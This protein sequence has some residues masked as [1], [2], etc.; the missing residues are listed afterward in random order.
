MTDMEQQFGGDTNFYGCMVDAFVDHVFSNFYHKISGD[1][2]RMWAPKID[3][4]RERIWRS[5]CFEKDPNDGQYSLKRPGYTFDLN[6]WRI[7]GFIDCTDVRTCRP[8]SGPVGPD[9][10]RRENS[11]DIQRAFYSSY[12]KSHGLKY[13]CVTLPNGMFGSVFGTALSHND[14]GVLNM[15][16]L[17]EYLLDLIPPTIGNLEFGFYRPALFGDSIYIPS[18]VLLR[19]IIN[20]LHPTDTQFNSDLNSARTRIEHH[21]GTLFN[22]FRLLSQ[23][24]R[25]KLLS[26]K[27][28]VNRLHLTI[29]L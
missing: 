24:H 2:M 17:Q 13:Q 15:S 18:Q 29:F 23:K 8:G 7:F 10:E 27:R 6:S 3:D 19:K 11:G 28:G 9:G 12:M 1:S 21:F 16:H 4:F 20:S 22:G 14:R 25:F 5:V 26:K